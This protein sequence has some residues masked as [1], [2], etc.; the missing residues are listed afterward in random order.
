MLYQAF[1]SDLQCAFQNIVHNIW[2]QAIHHMKVAAVV[3]DR[4]SSNTIRSGNVLM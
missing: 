3:E 2:C 1:K 4:I